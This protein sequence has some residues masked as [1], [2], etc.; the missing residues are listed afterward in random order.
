[1][2][3]QTV[4]KCGLCQREFPLSAVYCPYDGNSLT[5][6]FHSDAEPVFAVI[7][8]ADED[9]FIGRTIERRYRI[10]EAIG[11]GGMGTVYRAVHTE[12][13]RPFAIKLIRRELVSDAIATRRFRR[14]DFG[15][16]QP[17]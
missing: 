3:S 11:H 13:N 12:L 16:D 4:K 5:E 2:I 7:E 14:W 10:V 6:T 17:T 15:E 1:M 8:P 9:P